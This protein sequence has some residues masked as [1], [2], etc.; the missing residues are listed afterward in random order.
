MFC[1]E[2]LHEPVHSLSSLCNVLRQKT[3]I[4]HLGDKFRW[5]RVEKLG[6]PGLY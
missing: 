1:R 2:M 6:G 4:D 3:T 5:P